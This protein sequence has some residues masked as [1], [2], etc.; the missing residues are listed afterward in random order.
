[1]LSGASI[2]ETVE[3]AGSELLAAAA[4]ELELLSLAVP[5]ATPVLLCRQLGV[6]VDGE[7]EETPGEVADGEALVDTPRL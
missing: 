3:G 5:L 1:L 2:G 4:D 7:A 6:V